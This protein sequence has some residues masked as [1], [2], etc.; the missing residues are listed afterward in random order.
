[1][2]FRFQGQ[3]LFLTY[4]QT[5][6]ISK[7]DLLTFLTSGPGIKQ[8]KFCLVGHE[9]HLDGGDHFHAFIDFGKRFS[10][11][12]ERRYDFHNFHPNI[13]RAGHPKEC[14][15][16]CSKEGDTITFGTA[17]DFDQAGSKPT[18]HEL[19]SG[20]LD[21]ST[22]AGEFMRAVREADAYT[23]CTRYKQLEDMALS[24]FKR[25]DPY[26]SPYEPQDFNLPEGVESWLLEEFDEEVSHHRTSGAARLTNPNRFAANP[27]PPGS[28]GG[29]RPNPN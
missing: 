21:N 27:N 3:Y 23:F 7:D 28:R 29:V 14:L 24:V 18:R 16:Y 11:T 25:R 26:V 17:P 20:L 22:S 8:P 4:S 5:T 12:N 9:R 19:W 10:F 6:D 1:M 13:A 2:V 15:E